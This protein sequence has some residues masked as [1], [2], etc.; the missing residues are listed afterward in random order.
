MPVFDGGIEPFKK[1]CH[2][3]KSIGIFPGITQHTGAGSLI[4]GY[5]FKV[6]LKGML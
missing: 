4:S 2:P 6:I 5:I 1:N 3:K